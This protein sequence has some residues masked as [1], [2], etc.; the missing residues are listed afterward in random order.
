MTTDELASRFASTVGSEVR[1]IAEGTDRYRVLTPFT[2]DDG[3][4][5]G[6]VYKRDGDRWVLTDEGHTLMHLSYWMDEGDLNRGNRRKIVENT[7]TQFGIGERSGRFELPAEPEA[8]GNALFTFLQA[9]TKISDV[10]FL[11]RETVASTFMAD[12]REFMQERVPK[13][14]IALDW[15]DQS[16][17]AAGLYPVD[18]RING[19]PTPLYVFGLGTD[20]RIQEATII[21]QKFEGWGQPFKS[22]GIFEDQES[23]SRKAVA[24]F[25]DVADKQFSSLSG[26]KDRI[27]QFLERELTAAS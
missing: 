19:M 4:G 27:G 1:L 12:L 9:L 10:S 15:H 3:D 16:R 11:D 6:I 7:I 24:R 18:F 22:I 14:R 20:Q 8:A 25:S 23:A 13:E 17:D 21:I 26:N 5:F 2:F